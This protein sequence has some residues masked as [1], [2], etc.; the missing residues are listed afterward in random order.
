MHAM[1]VRDDADIVIGKVVGHGKSVPRD[2][3]RREP[4]PAST[5][6][7]APLSGCS[8]RTSCSAARSS[9]STALRFPEGR[10]RLEDHVF[11]MR[12]YFAA[13]RISVLADYPCYHWVLR[14]RDVNASSGAARPADVLRVHGRG[15]RRG[16][17]AHRARAVPRPALPALVPREDA[18]PRREGPR[19][20]GP[21]DPARALRDDA[22]GRRRPLPGERRRVPPVQPAGALAAAAR[23]RPRRARGARRHRDRAARADP[24]GAGW[25]PGPVAEVRLRAELD[26]L[27]FTRAGDRLLWQGADATD[28]LA[29]AARCSCCSSSAR[30]R[31]STARRPR[32]RPSSSTA[33]TG[34]ARC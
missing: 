6:E 26:G 2:L 4:R 20:P 28:A 5:C 29:G 27:R 34:C 15:A 11:L 14:D 33:A 23:G 25:R 1:A 24:V 12:A 19:E 18:Q 32:S 3:F 17:R 21:G 31:R 22:R 30:A 13:P 8:R 9:T 7:W 16:R 10:R